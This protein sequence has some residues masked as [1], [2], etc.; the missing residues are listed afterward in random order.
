MNEP[1]VESVLDPDNVLRLSIVTST[2]PGTDQ[3]RRVAEITATRLFHSLAWKLNHI[4][5]TRREDG[6]VEHF[7]KASRY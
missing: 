3:A 6:K 1:T 4:A 5:S 7:F 2:Y